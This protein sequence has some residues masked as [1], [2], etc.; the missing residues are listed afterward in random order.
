MQRSA[1]LAGCRAKIRFE[2]PAVPTV[3]VA[4]TVHSR[5]CRGPV[6]LSE[7]QIQSMPIESSGMSRHEP[8][9]RPEINTHE[10]RLKIRRRR[11]GS[12]PST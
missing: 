12:R 4:I 3:R 2:S 8:D 1:R 6:T 7:N 11:A 5:Q 10:R 9:G